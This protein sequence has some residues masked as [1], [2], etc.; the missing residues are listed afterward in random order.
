VQL[1]KEGGGAMAPTNGEKEGE[2]APPNRKP[3]RG[4]KKVM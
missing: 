3:K 1:D 2:D 4:G